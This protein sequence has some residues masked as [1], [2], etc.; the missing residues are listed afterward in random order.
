MYCRSCG[1]ELGD[2]A[3]ACT[4]CGHRPYDGNKFCPNCGK[5]TQEGAVIC[6]SCGVALKAAGAAA[7]EKS[8]VIAGILNWLWSGVGNIYLGQT[9]KG[10]VFCVITGCF[11]I[12]D[13]V[14]CSLGALIHVPYMIVMIIDAVL[15]ANRIGKGESISEWKFF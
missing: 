1:A 5:E 3:V 14:T 9:T 4:K 7:G 8:P 11:V 12:F 10:V 6:T 15:L 2:K 13:I